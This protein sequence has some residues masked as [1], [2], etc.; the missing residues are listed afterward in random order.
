L[1]NLTFKRVCA[2][3]IDYILIT[4][5]SAALVQIS[6]INPKYDEYMELSTTYNNLL[7]DFN[8]N[9]MDISEVAEKQQE[10]SYDLNKNG[11]VYIIGSITISLLYFGVFAYFTKGQTLGKKVMNIKIV[12]AK[13]NKELKIYQYFIRTVLL[14]GILLNLVIL[15]AICFGRNTYNSIFNISSNLNTILE[16]AIFVTIL[17]NGRGIHDFVSGTKVISTKEKNEEILTTKNETKIE[18][19]ITVIKPK[20]KTKKEN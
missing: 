11:Y 15:I 6:F 3:L 7:Q 4:F 19:E 9:K 10:L 17:L 16:I 14:N 8:D 20:K 18:E 13:E 5:L 12:S 1:T 2:Y